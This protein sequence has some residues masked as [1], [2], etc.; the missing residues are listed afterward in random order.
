MH[1]HGGKT[2]KLPKNARF[3][4]CP[5]TIKSCRSPDGKGAAFSISSPSGKIAIVLPHK[6]MEASAKVMAAAPELLAALRLSHAQL[7]MVSEYGFDD[8]GTPIKELLH[9]CALVNAESAIA[10][11]IP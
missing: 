7:K 4:D 11:A 10:S 3:A 2:L 5:W 8:A 9:P 1:E 6:N